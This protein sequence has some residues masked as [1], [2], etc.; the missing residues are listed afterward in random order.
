MSFKSHLKSG[1]VL[2]LVFG[3][4]GMAIVASAGAS[5]ADIGASQSGANPEAIAAPAAMQCNPCAA[6]QCNPC[7]AKSC[8][9]CAAMQ[10]NPCAA[11]GCNPCGGC[12]PCA[13]QSCNPCGGCNPCGACNPCAGGGSMSAKLAC[14]V[15]RVAAAWGCNP[16]AAKGCNPC[17]GCNPCNP[18]G[19]M[20]QCNPCAAKQCNPCAAKG[21]N[22]CAASNPCAAQGCNPC[23]GCNPCAGGT[24]AEITDAE[25]IAAYECAKESLRSTYGEYGDYVDGASYN[26]TPYVSGTHGMRYVNNYGNDAASAYGRFEDAG[27]L[28]AGAML[29]KDSF[30]VGADGSVS[31]GPLF[32]M[33][34]M[35]AGFAADQ[36]DWKYTMVLPGGNVFGVTGGQNSAGVNFCAECHGFVAEQDHL[37]FLPE[38]YRKSD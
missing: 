24:G 13:A 23:G 19:A 1:T 26:T 11:K 30:S 21:C 12:N 36:G 27:T 6:R 2:P 14:A 28:P 5:S 15:P 4:A 37:Y 25:A 18:C 33:E 34:K 17:G 7:A 8:N 32:L 31:L 38:E 10:C 16:C 29:A 20:R 9:P 22:P 3:V 35:A